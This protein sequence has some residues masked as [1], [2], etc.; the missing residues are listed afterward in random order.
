[1]GRQHKRRDKMSQEEDPGRRNSQSRAQPQTEVNESD[2]HS[3]STDSHPT[4]VYKRSGSVQ[5]RHGGRCHVHIGD[6]R[7]HL[8]K[9]FW[10]QSQTPRNYEDNEEPRSDQGI[11][12]TNNVTNPAN[13]PIAP[14]RT[15]EVVILTNIA[16]VVAI[17]TV[18]HT[19]P[20][21]PGGIDQ[22]SLL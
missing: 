5:R 3:S 12:N 2:S 10:A 11:Q 16:A 4:S 7:D 9:I 14:T 8:N 18:N 22:E 6:L 19:N 15:G 17:P 1:M 21:L 13:P 20:I